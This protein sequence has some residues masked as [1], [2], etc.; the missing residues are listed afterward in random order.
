MIDS[1]AHILPGIDDGAQTMA[2]SVDMVRAA[3]KQGFDALILTPHYIVD[4]NFESP[5][6]ANEALLNK[7][8]T[9][10]RAAGISM[11]LFL[12]NEVFFN[13]AVLDLI[14]NGSFKTMNDSRYLLV[15]TTR[16]SDEYYNFEIFL[17]KL[18]GKGYTPIIAHPER[19]E[20]VQN[21]PNILARLVE[22][23][24][25]AQLNILSLTG[26]YGESAKATAEILLTHNM[27]HF[28]VSDAHRVKSYEAFGKAR[29][30]AVNLIGEARV[31]TMLVENPKRLLVDALITP[32]DPSRY[33]NSKKKKRGLGS[34]WKK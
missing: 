20:F 12:G 28:L 18:Q 7:L 32:T 19:Y 26:F 15:E 34:I 16:N 22:H 2:Q 29:E 14:D 21:D 11:F 17:Y 6:A 23:G 13:S 4:T 1:H 8:K 25:L 10:V 9:A 33:E 27:V 3:K 31:A 5:V 24:S 30:V